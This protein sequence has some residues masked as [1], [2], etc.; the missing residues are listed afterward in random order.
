MFHNPFIEIVVLRI[1]SN[2]ARHPRG[3]NGRCPDREGTNKRLSLL[4]DADALDPGIRGTDS[5]Y[6]KCS[7]IIIM[8]N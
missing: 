4:P 8:K 3:V 5:L 7:S 6:F 2:S 1:W